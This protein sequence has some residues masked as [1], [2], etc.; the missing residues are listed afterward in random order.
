MHNFKTLVFPMSLALC[1]EDP[2]GNVPLGKSCNRYWSCQGGYPRLQRCPAMLVFDKKSL[3]CLVPPTEDCD[4]PSTTP[5][6][7]EEEEDKPRE[8]QQGRPNQGGRR[9][10][11]QASQLRSSASESQQNAA[12]SFV[13]PQVYY[14]QQQQQQEFSEEQ[15]YRGAAGNRQI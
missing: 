14:A 1:K 13:A 10:Q 4:V 11:V 9:Q 2:N 5:Q 15:Q 7:P 8:Q 6:P 3:R 12:S